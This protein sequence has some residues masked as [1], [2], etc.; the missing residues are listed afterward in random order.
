MRNLDVI[1]TGFGGC[2]VPFAFFELWADEAA[3]GAHTDFE[4][5]NIRLED[6]YSLTQIRYPNPEVRGV[7]FSNITA[8]DGVGMVPSVLQGN[9]AGVAMDGVRVE[10]KIAAKDAD[11]P[12]EV[13]GGAAEPVYRAGPTDA[14]FDYT[15]DHGVGFVRPRQAV[16]FRVI[17][18]DPG[19]KYQWLFG[20][21][22]GPGNQAEGAAVRH[23]FP[24]A[25]GTLLDGSG[26]FRVLLRATRAPHDEVW[27]SRGVVVAGRAVA[28]S[29]GPDTLAASVTRVDVGRATEYE[30]WLRIPSD[31]GYTLTLLT[32]RKAT[33]RVD[34]LAPV[35]SPELR[36]QVCGSMG[37]AVQPVRLSAAL[38]AGLHR[39]RIDLDPGVENEPG[40]NLG[41]GAPMLIWEGPGILPEAV[42][43]SAMVH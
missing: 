10:G 40:G 37:D 19:W 32:S 39:I 3:T 36:I 5:S 18:P 6:F 26:R 12:L 17:A 1:H 22:T 13:S 34:D 31:G 11:I 2:V 29:A 16:T 35:E 25:Q 30:G 4:F 14:S 33:L 43:A 38:A 28:A 21:G 15:P 41:S 8:M 24:D 42:P 27:V 7:T 9:V 23:A 20:D